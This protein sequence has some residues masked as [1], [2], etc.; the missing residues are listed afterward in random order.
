MYFIKKK[1]Q[2]R[3]AKYNISNC[4]KALCQISGQAV[5]ECFSRYPK[6]LPPN[7]SWKNYNLD[8]FMALC[9]TQKVN[10]WR[11]KGGEI[12]HKKVFFAGF[13]SYSSKSSVQMEKFIYK[14]QKTVTYHYYQQHPQFGILQV[15]P[16]PFLIGKSFLAA[17][18]GRL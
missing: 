8:S 2:K 15:Y 1:K 18:R 11:K 3:K 5:T 4:Q 7:I 13:F 9:A 16:D 6:L 14:L 10:A 17:F 12:E